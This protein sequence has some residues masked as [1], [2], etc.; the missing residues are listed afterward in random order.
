MRLPYC[1]GVAVIAACDSGPPIKTASGELIDSIK[2][3]ETFPLS[4][5]VKDSS[6]GGGER[7]RNG[8]ALMDKHRLFDLRGEFKASGVLDKGTLTIV[9]KPASGAERRS[10]FKSCGHEGVCAFFAEASA[11]GVVDHTPVLCRNP[12][13]CDKPK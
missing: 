6:L 12:V 1:L 8:V 10:T 5:D 7:L 3:E 4:N 13:P 2:F 11:S 9:V